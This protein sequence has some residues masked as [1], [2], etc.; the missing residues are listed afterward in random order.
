[1]TTHL[2]STIEL[3]E[4]LVSRFR[5]VLVYYLKDYVRWLSQEKYELSLQGTNILWSYGSEF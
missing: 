5:P 3:R 1:M 2:E 4:P